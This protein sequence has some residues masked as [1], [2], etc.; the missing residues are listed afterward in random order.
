MRADNATIAHRK[1]YRAPGSRFM[2]LQAP[3]IISPSGKLRPTGLRNNMAYCSMLDRIEK[4]FIAMGSPQKDFH[5]II[6]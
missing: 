6:N 1:A 4:A 3:A 5:E 2:D